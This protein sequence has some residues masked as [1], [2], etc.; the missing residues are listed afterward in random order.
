MKATRKGKAPAAGATALLAAW[1]E[2]RDPQI[3]D[4]LQ[5]VPPRFD[6]AALKRMKSGTFRSRAT[7]RLVALPDDPRVTVALVE[8]V[9]SAHWNGSSAKGL[10]ERLFAKL[11]ALRDRRAIAPLR[12]MLV[13]KPY[14]LGR[15]HL[16]WIL[17]QIAATAD[18]L[19]ALA[20]RTPPPASPWFA[21]PAK[22][23]GATDVAAL[24]AQVYAAPE[25]LELRSVIGDRL[26][27]LGDPRGEL[28]AATK[29]K[30]AQQLATR[31]AVYLA[32]GIA[33]VSRHLG[34]TYDRGFVDTVSLG[35]PRIGRR[36]WDEC[37]AEPAWATVRDVR[38]VAGCVPKWFFAEW[39]A[40][41]NLASLRCIRVGKVG[42]V[43]IERASATAPWKVVAPPSTKTTPIA[44]RT[45]EHLASALSLDLDM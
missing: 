18:A 33:K 45:L 27:E 23:D 25:D 38:L 32:G 1:R 43:V 31:H 26:Q 8:L 19:A 28:I 17:A 44:V 5:R 7:A 9:R 34:F 22:R 37:L 6:I 11:V 16:A 36:L 13:T 30:V 21:S 15:E 12:A 42:T 20:P 4:E 24:V 14:F 40:R 39:L 10:H 2:T 35:K 41:S 3:A 29:P